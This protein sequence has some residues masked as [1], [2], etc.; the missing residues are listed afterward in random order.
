MKQKVWA[1]L[2]AVML[3]LTMTPAAGFAAVQEQG[4]G[5]VQDV[6]QSEKNDEADTSQKQD[7]D[8]QK[9]T[10]SSSGEK[11]SAQQADE[12]TAAVTNGANVYEV[13]TTEDLSKAFDKIK[14][15]DAANATVIL[16]ANVTAPNT[17]ES[18]YLTAF[19][20]KDRHITV[21]SAEGETIHSLSFANRG[22]LNGSCTFDNVDVTGYML[23]CSGYKTIFTEN[24]TIHL[25]GTLYGGGYKEDVEST[26]VAVAASGS[27]NPNATNG[28]HNVIGG[29]YQGSVKGDTYLEITGNIQFT[30]GNHLTP[31]GVTGDGTS[32]DGKDSPDVS[33]GGNATLIY[34]NPNGSTS[35]AIEGTYGCEMKGDVTLDI[36]SGRANEICGTQEFVDKSII[37]GDLH[38][39]A[40]AAKYEN[41]NRTLRLNGNW[42]IVGAGHRFATMPGA[43]GNYTIGGNIVIDTYEN[44][45]GWDKG[46][47]PSDDVPEIFGALRG[48]VGGSITINA[49][50]SHVENIT[51]AS[52]SSNVK[53]DVTINAVNVELKNSYYEDPDYDEGDILANYKSNISG[54]SIVNVD[55]GDVNIVRLTTYK[56]VNENS[57]ITI[58]GSPKIRTGVLATTNYSSAP[59]NAVVELTG[60]TATIPFVQSATQVKVT[61]KSNVALDGLWLAGDLTVN[62][63]SRLKTDKDIVELEGD[64]AVNGT[65]EQLF[66]GDTGPDYDADI[67]GAM[68]VGKDGRYIAHGST[69]VAGDVDSAGLMALMKPAWFKGTYSGTDAELRLP[70]VQKE[71]NYNTGTIPLR[72]SK[73]ASGSTTVN[74]VKTD[75]WSTL[76]TPALGDNYILTKKDGSKPSQE[77]FLLGNEDAVNH[78]LF[79]KRTADA[80]GTDDHYMW[81][82]AT[83][84]RVTFDKNGG[85]TE[86]SPRV[87]TQ[88]R[89][90]ETRAYHFDLPEKNP[91][92]TAYKFKGWNTE[93]DGSGQT[94]TEKTDVTRSMTV[95]AQW[96]PDEACSVT[97]TPM[98]LT[99]YVGGNGYKG[100]IGADDKFATNDLPEMGYFVTLP[101]DILEKLGDAKA[102]ELSSKLVMTYDDGN[103]VTRKWK[104]DL[105]GNLK[106][107]T[108]TQAN[109]KKAFI[110]RILPSK[111]DGTSEMV[112]LRLQFTA[113][114]GSV[115]VDSSF[116]VSESDQFRNY[117]VDFFSGSLNEKLVRA[118]IEVDGKTITRPIK[119][120]TGSL[121]VRGNTDEKY[122]QI[123]SSEPIFAAS[124]PDLVL[125]AAA[126]KDTTYYLNHGNVI[127]ND[128]SSIRLLVDHS[129]DDGFLQNYLNQTHNTDGKYSYEFR[130]LDLVDTQNGNAYVTMGQNQKMKLYWP[131]PADASAD[132]EFHMMHFAALNRD[133][134]DNMN[135]LLEKEPAEELACQK[136]KIDG[137]EYIT[138]ETESFSPFALLYEKK[139]NAGGDDPKEP[140]VTPGDP[141]NSGSA[142]GTSS[143]GGATAKGGQTAS[144]QAETGQSGQPFTLLMLGVVLS[145]AAMLTLGITARKRRIKSNK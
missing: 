16:K 145:G 89:V 6:R 119:L 106:H 48:D 69:R 72:I 38:I 132:S 109:G 36:R 23:Y 96:E 75:D 67:A 20:V 86:A 129:L 57:K 53:G 144:G 27:I 3:L 117:K 128:P 127:V 97:I 5:S 131:V 7:A 43:T 121:K 9:S 139:T 49:H 42:P 14:E 10:R 78:D 26:Y 85:E 100:V 54:A 17:G 73:L 12:D 110:Y 30:S 111:V 99:I 104:F 39:I 11:A 61:G 8:A 92:R 2:L 70:V 101:E 93:A 130:Y 124:D 103:G 98:D 13:S 56:T 134:N 94:F 24:G 140:S 77:T 76:Q 34:D 138:F 33:V 25:S 46:A 55:G 68:T 125:A 29:S 31:G 102:D 108:V 137:K 59:E 1:C 74:T 19:G 44:V 88:D 35:P 45:W 22:I 62:A 87:M 123:G 52:N 122:S 15:S 120:G 107:S 71:K 50:G 141:G 142:E 118:E 21:K 135:E 83:G 28:R 115:M 58:T 41:T 114:D 90:A 18:Q 91:T 80:A 40:G 143:A 32:G 84:I 81:Q 66:V 60:C 37:R 113:A 126:Q 112:P 116:P 95:Y 4:T 79:L 64:V 133:S 82:V 105:Y 51:G 47:K 65:W 63:G 136:V